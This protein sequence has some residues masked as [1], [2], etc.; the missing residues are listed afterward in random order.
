MA[1]FTTQTTSYTGA[2]RAAAPPVKKSTGFA[3]IGLGVV[4]AAVLIGLGYMFST[5]PSSSTMGF[6]PVYGVIA[7]AVLIIV[8]VILAPR[9][10]AF[11]RDVYPDAAARYD[12]SWQCQ[13]CGNVFVV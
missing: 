4:V 11:N 1:T 8:G 7:G 12:R 6:L 3:L 2:A 5:G 13:R 9:D 10:I